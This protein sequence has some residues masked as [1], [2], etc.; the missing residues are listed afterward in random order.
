MSYNTLSSD[1]DAIVAAWKLD[2]ALSAAVVAQCGAGKS[3]KYFIGVDAF[4]QPELSNAP[5]VCLMPGD[6]QR[7]EERT[8][9]K[10]SL[11]VGLILVDETLTTVADVTKM[12]GIGALEAIVTALESALVPLFEQMANDLV[13]PGTITTEI[14]FPQFRATWSYE[15]TERYA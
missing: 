13:D 5:Y 2:N 7:N 15:F 1:M 8:E 10:R 12:H 4:D 11:R 14:Y 6:Y 3:L 9:R